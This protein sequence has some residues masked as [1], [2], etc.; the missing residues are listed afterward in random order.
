MFLLL[1]ELLSISLK[2]SS[3]VQIKRPIKILETSLQK[4]SGKGKKEF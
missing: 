4:S 1:R 2:S 3:R